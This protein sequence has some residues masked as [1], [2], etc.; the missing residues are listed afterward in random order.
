MAKKSKINKNT[1]Y[2]AI[3]AIAVILFAMYFSTSGNSANFY[4][5]FAPTRTTSGGALPPPP[6]TQTISDSQLGKV[7]NL[8]PTVLSKDVNINTGATFFT[9]KV[10]N[11]GYADAGAF[12]VQ[13][14]AKNDAVF[15][16]NNKIL[17]EDA[18]TCRISGLK[19]GE[20]GQCTIQYNVPGWA[21]GS[22]PASVTWISAKVDSLNEV[23]EGNENDNVITA[24]YA[25]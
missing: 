15:D 9:T 21:S 11:Q 25:L 23:K 17:D 2:I 16:S 5:A 1:K 6:P 3:A 12:R 13:L 19:S 18:G 22:S 14:H 4:A 20:T 7:P 10:I 8:T 24:G